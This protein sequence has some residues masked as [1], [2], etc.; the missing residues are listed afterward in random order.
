MPITPT[1]CPELTASTLNTVVRHLC[2]KCTCLSHITSNSYGAF[3][4]LKSL[5]GPTT[6]ESTDVTLGTR[7]LDLEMIDG[8]GS[9]DI[10]IPT[11]ARTLVLADVLH[12]YEAPECGHHTDNLNYSDNLNFNDPPTAPMSMYPPADRSMMNYLE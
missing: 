12:L 3:M 10:I 11:T 9:M 5:D 8:F 6:L 7:H 2:D 4:T 1:S